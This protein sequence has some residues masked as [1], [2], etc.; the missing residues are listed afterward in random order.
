MTRRSLA[1][2]LSVSAL[3]L[4]PAN[5]PA[6]DQASA[7]ALAT[8]FLAQLGR[9]GG[10]IA[11]LPAAGDGML[12]RSILQSSRMWVHA[13]NPDNGSVAAVLS[14]VELTGQMG[15][16]AWVEKGTPAR[17]PYTDNLV[18][19]VV[20]TNLADADLAGVSADEI[21]RVLSPNGMAFIGR[22][23]SEGTGLSAAAL[24]A[25]AG[26][27]AG[28]RVVS[29]ALGTWAVCT[30]PVPAN[31]DD[32][33]H[34][35]HG[36]D[37]NPVSTDSSIKW[38]YLPQWRQKPYSASRFCGLVTANGRAY[39]ALNLRPSGIVRSLVLFAYRLTNGCPL[40]SCVLEARST[41]EVFPQN[42][43][44]HGASFMVAADRGVYAAQ[45]NSVVLFDGETGA[46]SDSIVMD[47]SGA[48]WV[49]WLAISNGLIYGL[50]GD[51]TVFDNTWANVPGACDSL[52]CHY[53]NVVVAYNL[54]TRA[55]AWRRTLGARIDSREVGIANGRLFFYARGERVGCLNAATGD[56]GWSQRDATMLSQLEANTPSGSANWTVYP[57]GGFLCSPYGVYICSPDDDPMYALSA[58]NG[59]ILWTAAKGWWGR[60]TPK[61]ILGTTLVNPY[62]SPADRRYVDVTSGAAT[63]A[64]ATYDFGGGCGV[65]AASPDGFFGNWGGQACSFS[66]SRNLSYQNF[67]TDCGIGAALASGM[68]IYTVTGCVC[69]P[70]RGTVASRGAGSFV[71]ERAAVESERLEAGPAAGDLNVQVQADSLDWWTWQANGRHSAYVP[72]DVPT[73][74]HLVCT[75]HPA[76]AY[77]T[78][79]SVNAGSMGG[80][81]WDDRS[82]G[83]PTQPVTA[84]TYVFWGGTDGYLRGYDVGSGQ[85]VWSYSTGGAVRTPPTI[86]DGC[87]YAGSEDGYAYCLEAQS[88]RLVWRFRG[89]PADMRFNLYGHLASTWP[90]NSGVTASGT[91]VVFAAGLMDNC[92]THVYALNGRTGAIVWQ[93]NTSGSAYNARD[94]VGVSPAGYG[95]V[96]KDKYW[97]RAY[98]GRN[99]IYALADGAFLALPAAV[100][101]S[102]TG[103]PAQYGSGMGVLDTNHVLFGGRLFYSDVSD[104]GSNDRNHTLVVM[105]VDA[106]GNAVYPEVSV[107]MNSLLGA[108][109][110]Q[111]FVC[112]NQSGGGLYHETSWIERWSKAAYV[113]LVD[114]IVQANASGT[115][116]RLTWGQSTPLTQWSVANAQVNGIALAR[117][118]VAV[119]RSADFANGTWYLHLMSRDDGRTLWSTQ[120]PCEPVQNGVAINR[121]GDIIVA[122]RSGA[123]LCYGSGAVGVTAGVPVMPQVQASAVALEAAA[124]RTRS[125][126]AR[127]ASFAVPA[128][129]QTAQVSQAS[130][131]ERLTGVRPLLALRSE[132][133]ARDPAPNPGAACRRSPEEYARSHG[134]DDGYT[135]RNL[136]WNCERPCLAVASVNASSGVKANTGEC[137]VDRDLATRWT[138]SA[139][140]E[141]WVS[142][143]L[144]STKE[145]SAVS[146]VWYDRSS[147]RTAFSLATSL[148]GKV[149]SQVDAGCLAGRGTNTS[150]RSFVSAQARFVRLTLLP[151]TGSVCPSV[152]EVGIHGDVVQ[153]R[154]SVK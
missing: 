49:K 139:K 134:G 92:G 101:S 128:G 83:R 97:L 77:D 120:L 65:R 107:A 138:P 25:W 6:L 143:D 4:V 11:S 20:V 150:Q 17:L 118:A 29:N 31:H 87:V 89:A 54:T 102:A 7:N 60:T 116:V 41:T 153:R 132:P 26:G 47:P 21:L 135:P 154:A 99:G 75:Y 123:V 10:G 146:V 35:L 8:D 72:V 13:M 69:L 43:S 1:I 147:G 24:T 36:P 130:A 98:S 61:L 90:V 46:R 18:D 12:A 109:D 22:A 9:S 114:S 14:L 80:G 59:S 51:S 5:T 86:A 94:R 105:R 88:G 131:V 127:E 15:T 19:M 142:Y 145:V 81:E 30:R 42:L 110:D 48:R 151:A 106:Q 23:T 2:A 115:A 67:K 119:L 56:S 148:D 38:P 33:T 125:A 39:V 44:P 82:D 152:Y 96:V 40:W 100:A 113:R 112:Q 144:G 64:Y 68:Q 3:S 104:R 95:V 122:L 84:G 103:G 78:T 79:W 133:V 55:E 52:M 136:R 28:W 141:Q 16:R 108:W 66:Q 37:N 91:A 76:F 70:I 57:S 71:F 32:W 93:N 129:S 27:R 126:D 62:A 74:P 149:F 45:R 117:N 121:N 140:G 111:V 53:G 58:T 34:M 124:W 137:T 50:V 73:S 85:L 63:S